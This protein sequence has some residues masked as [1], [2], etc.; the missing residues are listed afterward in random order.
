MKFVI[1][2]IA[3]LSISSAIA[4]GAT[5]ASTSTSTTTGTPEPGLIC[6]GTVVC[7]DHEEWCEPNCPTCGKPEPTGQSC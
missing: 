7:I 5:R 3:A 6:R 2:T 4:A 1:A